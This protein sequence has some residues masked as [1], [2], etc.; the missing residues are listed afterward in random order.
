MVNPNGVDPKFYSPSLDGEEVR[1]RYGLQDKTVIGFIGT[2]GLWHGAEVLADAYGRLLES[3]PDLADSLRLLMIGDGVTR[4]LVEDNLASHGVRDLAVLTGL[5]PQEEGPNHL[6]ACDILIAPHVPNPDGT[7]FFGSPTKLF[8][9]M[10]MGKGIV[11]SR[12]DQ[13][14]DVLVHDETAW[15]VDAGNPAH[16]ADGIR[17]LVGNTERRRRLGRAARE[18]VV[19]AHTWKQHTARIIEKL[20]ER[21]G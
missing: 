15:M 11:A 9:Y 16:L 2:F 13:I 5:V 18:R 17:E 21:C 14:A 7:P 19:A 8:E 20:K 12:L 4:Q 6:A 10:A 1:S 3:T